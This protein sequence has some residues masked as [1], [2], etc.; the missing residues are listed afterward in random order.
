MMGNTNR[1]QPYIFIKRNNHYV[2]KPR[3]EYDYRTYITTSFHKKMNTDPLSHVLTP[4]SSLLDSREQYIK[5]LNKRVDIVNEIKKDLELMGWD[6]YPKKY[7]DDQ[8]RDIKREINLLENP[9]MIPENPAFL[10]EY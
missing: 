8:I 2:T 6:N 5:Y 4:L 3:S 10:F 1:K 7:I 9:D